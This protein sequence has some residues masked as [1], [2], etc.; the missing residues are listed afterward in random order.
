MDMSIVFDVPEGVWRFDG[1]PQSVPVFDVTAKVADA[2]VEDIVERILAEEEVTDDA[3]ALSV[4][5]IHPQ[6]TQVRYRVY[7]LLHLCHLT[8]EVVEWHPR[9]SANGIYHVPILLDECYDRLSIVFRYVLCLIFQF[10]LI[11]LQFLALRFRRILILRDSLELRDDPRLLIEVIGVGKLGE[12][13][14]AIMHD[15]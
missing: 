15:G 11:C 4:L 12:Y 2:G 14:V 13:G 7:G 5:V 1:L 6:T 9:V 3:H 8:N 10:L